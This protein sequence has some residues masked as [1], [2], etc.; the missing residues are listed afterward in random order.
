MAEHL[1]LHVEENSDKFDHPVHDGTAAWK[2]V[3]LHVTTTPSKPHPMAEHVKQHVT[4]NIHLFDHPEHDGTGP[5]S[6][7]PLT[8]EQ[9]KTAN[10]LFDAMDRDQSGHIDAME[11]TACLRT[12]SQET[13]KILNSIIELG[14]IHPADFTK[15]FAQTKIEEGN[16]TVDRVLAELS[17][18]SR[19]ALSADEE[20]RLRELYVQMDANGDDN[21]DRNEIAFLLRHSQGSVVRD[22]LDYVANYKGFLTEDIFLAAMSHAKL[23]RGHAAFRGVLTHLHE[24]AT[25]GVTE[26][27]LVAELE[28]GWG[29]Y[30]NGPAKPPHI[31][32]SVLRPAL[33]AKLGRPVLENIYSKKRHATTTI[34][35]AARNV[36]NVNPQKTWAGEMAFYND[37]M[38]FL[39]PGTGIEMGDTLLHIAARAFNQ[40]A[41][42]YLISHGIALSQ[43]NAAGKTAY[44]C[45]VGTSSVAR[46][47]RNEFPV[48]WVERLW[49][50][51]EAKSPPKKV[52][53]TA[54]ELAEEDDFFA[55]ITEA[56]EN[57]S[58]D[59]KAQ[60]KSRNAKIREDRA[61]QRRVALGKDLPNAVVKEPTYPYQKHQYGAEFSPSPTRTSTLLSQSPRRSRSRSPQRLQPT[62]WPA[63]SPREKNMAQIIHE[64]MLEPAAITVSQTNKYPLRTTPRKQPKR[65][66]C[67]T[68]D[69]TAGW[70]AR[71]RAEVNAGAGRRHYAFA[72]Q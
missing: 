19:A 45:I 8:D 30:H 32:L 41:V 9:F 4:Q 40:T 15:F 36:S 38:W 18:S 64:N 14:D 26:S 34:V 70:K 56:Y 50:L 57:R 21:L 12:A 6:A 25:S 39:N 60:L 62:E 31:I 1:K 42:K 65:M 47:T 43:K 29:E 10:D 37:Q 67:E 13:Y 49:T 2:R 48:E 28:S 63:H 53:L 58:T 71:I 68:V 5:K 3:K 22:L 23:Q 51:Q 55:E 72:D 27:I 17:C 52:V 44:E 24:M 20:V 11:L 7:P 35:R 46:L 69:E 66:T 16:A 54:E 59:P 33:V 61:Q